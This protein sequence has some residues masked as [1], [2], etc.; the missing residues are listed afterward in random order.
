MNRAS[1]PSSGWLESTLMTQLVTHV[2]SKAPAPG[3]VTLRK[4]NAS[5]QPRLL[6]SINHCVQ[7]NSEW[8]LQMQCQRTQAAHSWFPIIL[9]S[10]RR[11]GAQESKQAFFSF[12]FLLLRAT[13]MAYG[14]SQARG[15][16]GAV[17]ASLCSN[18]GS[19]LRL[20]PISQLTAMPDP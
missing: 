5:A 6:S 15:R 9:A 12:L 4:R 20:R 14:G 19:E 3:T 11:R 2:S 13:P 8:A 1:Q 17:A 10:L 16:I 18:A 7:Q